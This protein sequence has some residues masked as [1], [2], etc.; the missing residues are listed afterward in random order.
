MN[1]VSELVIYR[2]RL[3]Q[4]VIDS[5]SQELLETIEQV[6]GQLLIYKI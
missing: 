4:I 5:K 6:R 3:E 1:M 2:T